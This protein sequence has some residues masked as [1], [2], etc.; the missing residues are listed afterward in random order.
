MASIILHSG[1]IVLVDDEDYPLLSRLKWH[2]GTSGKGKYVVTNILIGGRN[3]QLS[4]SR[5][6]TGTIG[7]SEVV[8][9][10]NH[11]T[12]DNRKAN[13][14]RCTQGQNSKNRRSRSALKGVTAA[15]N[16]WNAKIHSDGVTHNL[17]SFPTVETAAA[18]YDAAA[19]RLHG[20]F[21]CLN[22][23][24][25]KPVPRELMIVR[26]PIPPR[27]KKTALSPTEEGVAKYLVR[28]LQIKHIGDLMN[29]SPNTVSTYR[30]RVLGKLGLTSNAD[31]IRLYL[32]RERVAA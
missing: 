5:L 22:Y 19:I 2:A 13:L 18:A 21:A 28:G 9:H 31:L 23:P 20:E 25:Q 10:I 16:S 4:M 1:H 17:G 24:D 27:P 3:V 6:I 11:D 29:L 7:K 8:D 15:G 26:E 14:R 12:F 30:A 32:E